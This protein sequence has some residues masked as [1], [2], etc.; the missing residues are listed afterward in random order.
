VC[1]DVGLLQRV[2]CRNVSLLARC[3]D[4]V[5][6]RLKGCGGAAGKVRPR[7]VPHEGTGDRAARKTSSAVD[8]GGLVL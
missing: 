7:T 3:G 4:V 1:V 8:D 2:H 5:G 6:H